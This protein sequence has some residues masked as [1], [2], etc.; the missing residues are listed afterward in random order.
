[1][2]ESPRRNILLMNRSMFTGFA[3]PEPFPVLFTSLHISFTFSRTMLQCRSKAFTLP[4]SFLLFRQL[5]ST[6]AF[7]F[8]L[9]INTDSGPPWLCWSLSCVYERQRG[10]QRK[11]RKP[12]DNTK[13]NGQKVLGRGPTLAKGALLPPLNLANLLGH[14]HKKL[15]SW[16]MRR[17]R[18]DLGVCVQEKLPDQPSWYMNW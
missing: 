1:M 3:L 15:R 9:C 13:R 14:H 6:C 8:T 4:R 10:S 16:K 11:Q 18:K 5:I 12:R 2:T 17:L 7:V